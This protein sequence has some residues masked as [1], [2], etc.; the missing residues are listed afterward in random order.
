MLSF[1]LFFP[2]PLAVFFFPGF[3][4]HRHQPVA[5]RAKFALKVNLL[6]VQIQVFPPE[7]NRRELWVLILP[8]VRTAQFP[9]F[10][11]I[12]VVDRAPRRD[13]DLIEIRGELVL[14]QRIVSRKFMEDKQLRRR[15]L[16]LT[17]DQVLFARLLEQVFLKQQPIQGF[18]ARPVPF[19]CCR[20]EGDFRHDFPAGIF[21]EVG[22]NYP[23]P[24]DASDRLGLR[25][26]QSV[27]DI[28]IMR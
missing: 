6:L 9:D 1:P 24:L 8:G 4:R 22:N 7:F 17:V 20:D 27:H 5:Q 10:I 16:F 13:D 15:N 23:L 21:V 3:H 12:I 25:R 14:N 26:I 19:V 18:Q 28:H 2:F 11:R